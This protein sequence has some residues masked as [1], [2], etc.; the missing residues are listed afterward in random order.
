MYQPDGDLLVAAALLHDVGYALRS[1][2]R[3]STPSTERASFAAS[4]LPRGWLPWSPGTPV[5]G[6]RRSCGACRRSWRSSRTRAVR[7]GT[8]C[9]TAT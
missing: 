8:R 4:V 5:P 2:L 7:S 1:R 3:G 9:G 6:G